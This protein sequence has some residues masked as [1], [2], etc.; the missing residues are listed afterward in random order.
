LFV[1][2]DTGFVDLVMDPH[3]SRTLRRVAA[4]ARRLA[5]GDP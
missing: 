4:P 5:S 1:D 3:D 2:D